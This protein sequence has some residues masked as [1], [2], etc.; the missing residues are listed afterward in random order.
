M[1]ESLDLH[2]EAGKENEPTL[3]NL[4]PAEEATSKDKVEIETFLEEQ[5]SKNTNYKTRSDLNA[6]KKFCGSLKECR[7][8]E[9][10]PANELDLL[11][12][13][14]FISV[15]KQNG[16]EYEPGTLSGFQRS[17]Q[18]YLHEKG[19]LINILKDN[20]FSKSRE[21]LAA[22][23][24]N[25]VRQGKGNCPNAT[26][27]LT[28]AEEDALFENGQFG[29]QD[30]KSL[31]RAL[32]WF[33]SLHFGWRARDESR[34]LC[35]GDVGLASDP[36]TDSEYLVWKSERGSKTR[37]G[38]DGGHQRAFEPKA[39]ACNN[40]SRCPVEFYKAFRSHRSEAML[41]PD[42]PFY[43]AINHRRTPNDKVWYLDRPLGK[44][45][46]GKF[47]K[48][49][50]AAAKLDDTNKKKVSNHSVRKT[51]VGRLLEADVQPNF[52]AQLSGHK[53]LKSLDSYH[54]ASLKRQREMSA[55]L[56]RE[57]GTPARFEEN[58]AS[59]STTTQQN[60]FTVQQIQ[61][62]AIFAGAQ[63]DK[64][65]GCT[66]NINV[67]CGDQSKIAKLNEN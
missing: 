48:D 7:A 31:Q 32:W 28:E 53:N 66:F 14:F 29:V 43:L 23:R 17:F 3:A 19:S 67:F 44:N 21:V 49:A 35:W 11:L 65:E 47:L 40:K 52:V 50:F 58:K 1:E 51:S 4:S 37:T 38:Q 30:P 8:L 10:I 63:I 20:E 55:I 18:R 39:H 64:F 24:K 61:P 6:W 36:E 9:N 59:T 42:A 34:K 26:R 46:I 33:L 15:R 12:C 22:K 56:S 62:Q 60:V 57:P 45:E 25:L 41:E 13:K 5:R 16:T 27:E 54:S 2:E